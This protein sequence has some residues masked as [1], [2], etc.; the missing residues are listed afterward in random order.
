MKAI[1]L[2]LLPLTLHNV[3]SH[4]LSRYRASR[5]HIIRTG[6]EVLL[7]THLFEMREL[8]AQIPRGI[9]FEQ[10]GDEGWTKAWWRTYTDMHVIL[11]LFQRQQCQ[12]LPFTAL[13]NQAFC[14]RLYFP[15]QHTATILGYPHQMIDD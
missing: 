8:F 10:V 13:R 12:P 6:P 9:P 14:F 5:S 11:I 1:S 7:S 3:A 2:A 15:R 4:R